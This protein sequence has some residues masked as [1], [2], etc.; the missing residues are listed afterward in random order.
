MEKPVSVAEIIRNL[1]YMSE[2]ATQYGYTLSDNERREMEAY[3]SNL[4]GVDQNAL[5]A[6]DSERLEVEFYSLLER[7]T[8]LRNLKFAADYLEIVKSCSSTV[9]SFSELARVRALTA[10]ELREKQMAAKALS[11][12]EQKLKESLD[13]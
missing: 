3:F 13:S 12:V 6:A 4:L 8:R 7:H 10:I 2:V 1:E 11:D 9:D 5:T